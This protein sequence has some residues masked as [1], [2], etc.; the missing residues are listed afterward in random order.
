M[1]Q[2]SIVNG[3]LS[4]YYVIIPHDFQRTVVWNWVTNSFTMVR[5]PSVTH[6]EE[7]I[8]AVDFWVQ[9]PYIFVVTEQAQT[10]YRCR[11]P[12][13]TSV[14]SV[15]SL[16]IVVLRDLQGPHWELPCLPDGYSQELDASF[17]RTTRYHSLAHPGSWL[18]PSQDPC[19]TAVTL[20]SHDEVWSVVP[21]EA[22]TMDGGLIPTTKSETGGM[23]F[24]DSM[25]SHTTSGTSST[26]E[27]ES[28]AEP[29]FMAVYEPTPDAPTFVGHTSLWGLPIE[30]PRLRTHLDLYPRSRLHLL[31]PRSA[32]E[33]SLLLVGLQKEGILDPTTKAVVFLFRA[34]A[35]R[36]R[37]GQLLECPVEQ[38]LRTDI[39][40]RWNQ[41]GTNAQQHRQRLMPYEHFEH[42]E[43]EGDFDE[44]EEAGAGD[45]WLD[46]FTEE[47]D[48]TYHEEEENGTR[49]QNGGFNPVEAD[50]WIDIGPSPVTRRIKTTSAPCSLSGTFLGSRA[51]PSRGVTPP[52]KKQIWLMRYD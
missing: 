21:P 36:G 26:T 33:S 15:N 30:H 14:P 45:V 40:W 44:L 50:T 51:V 13:L 39:V 24:I 5:I 28:T 37:T 3:H 27:L 1:F 25:P 32:D 35:F 43:L 52:Y 48:E 38:E 20:H 2:T 16:D 34:Y 46:F 12:A 42:T 31:G 10:L 4:G 7:G 22:D 8:H 29:R 41:E 47:L 49:D 6:G 18:P 9:P 17:Q 19:L 23:Y 11:I